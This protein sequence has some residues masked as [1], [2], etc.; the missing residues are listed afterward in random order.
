M[1]GSEG[2]QLRVPTI[3]CEPVECGQRVLG[4]L[5]SPE[6]GSSPVGVFRALLREC[7]SAPGKLLRESHS[8][9]EVRGGDDVARGRRRRTRI[10]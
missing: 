6:W 4:Y 7:S 3:L 10:D 1:S 9:E 5:L 2:A 8:E